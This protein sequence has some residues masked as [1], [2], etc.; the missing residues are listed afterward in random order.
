MFHMTFKSNEDNIAVIYGK[1]KKQLLKYYNE[2]FQNTIAS[3]G[4]LQFL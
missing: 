4:V 3:I 1:I 2:K